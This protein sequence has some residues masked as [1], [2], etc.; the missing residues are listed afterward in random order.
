MFQNDLIHVVQVLVRA[1]ALVTPENIR[2]PPSPFVVNLNDNPSLSP[3]VR[4]FPKPPC[5]PENH[6][7]DSTGPTTTVA[8]SMDTVS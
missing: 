3:R 5:A 7:H 6:A 4:S 2:P 8:V 1:R